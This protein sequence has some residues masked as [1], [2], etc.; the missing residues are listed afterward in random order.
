MEKARILS[1]FFWGYLLLQILIGKMAEKYGAKVILAIA[2]VASSISTIAIPFAAP[3]GYIAIVA[4]RVF[5]GAFQVSIGIH[6]HHFF[7]YLVLI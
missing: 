2:M 4:L 1:S 5:H 7:D 6:L 3:Y